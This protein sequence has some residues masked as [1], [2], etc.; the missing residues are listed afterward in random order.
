MMKKYLAKV[1]CWN[2]REAE[3]PPP[4]VD[5]PEE[6]RYGPAEV[7]ERDMLAA[8]VLDET[9]ESAEKRGDTEANDDG[10]DDADVRVEIR[11]LGLLAGS[12]LA[13]REAPE[14]LFEAVLND[15]WST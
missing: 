3:L 13:V 6:K 10:D 11:R 14:R 2:Q 9:G 4:E 7:K 8:G 5:Y 15:G 1:H 12:R